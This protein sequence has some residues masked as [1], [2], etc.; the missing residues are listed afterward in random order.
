MAH[1]RTKSTG[2]GKAR[3][4]LELVV[5]VGAFV[6]EPGWLL[7]GW[8]LWQHVDH[9]RDYILGLP[10]PDLETM[11]L[12][13]ATYSHS[14][15]VSRSLLSRLRDET[16]SLVFSSPVSVEYWAC[17]REVPPEW[18]DELGRWA[19]SAS[20]QYVRTH[21]TRVRSIQKWVAEAARAKG[22]L[23]EEEHWAYFAEY[24][25][26]RGTSPEAATEQIVK[27][28]RILSRVQTYIVPVVSPRV[29]DPSASPAQKYLNEES[30]GEASP[31]TPSHTVA[32]N[33]PI[34]L[35]AFVVSWRRGFKRL[36]KVGECHMVP[37]VYYFRFESFGSACPTSEHYD[38]PCMICFK[39]ADVELDDSSSAGESSS[40]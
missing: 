37:G 32:D 14:T 31:M 10:S 34:S 38:A 15:A 13:E 35:G 21:L 23:D 26:K 17:L 7:E 19:G 28:T 9:D 5:D 2:V 16:G 30:E 24:L 40:S 27:L 20:A 1:V 11:R 29:Q 6:V 4:T 3:E 12:V 33:P 25:L 36:H 22:A 39:S 8:S 18:I